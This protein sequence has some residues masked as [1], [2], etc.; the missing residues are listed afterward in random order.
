MD[1]ITALETTKLIVGVVVSIVTAIAG[2]IWWMRKRMHAVAEDV[3][4]TIEAAQKASEG[5][6][7]ALD[8]DVRRN[9]RKVESLEREMGDVKNSLENVTN[10]MSSMPSREDI[11]NLTLA[12]QR[13]EGN[14][15]RLDD[16]FEERLKPIASI[17]ER[18]QELLLRGM[19]D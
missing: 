3:S 5:K 7:T 1:W 18:M 9:S 12:M 16:K 4:E 10:A 13:S 11:H 6:L 19:K 2:A 15:Q 8:E 17:M 14:I